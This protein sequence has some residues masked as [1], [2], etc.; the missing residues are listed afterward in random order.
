MFDR[1]KYRKEYT[2]AHKDI[3]REYDKIYRKMHKEKRKNYLES[4]KHKIKEQQRKNHKK[5]RIH[6]NEKQK[7]LRH[8]KGISKKYREE[9]NGGISSTKQYKQLMR[10]RRRSL[11]KKA[12]PLTIE[13]IQ[14]VYEDN[15]KLYGTLTCYLCLK[16]IQFGD[17]SIDHK[18]PLCRSGT[19]EYENLGVA[20]FICNCRKHNKTEEGY[21]KELISYVI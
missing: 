13:T 14:Q 6:M 20:H 7:E 19:N 9:C 10:I 2:E 8:K 21:R 4:N 5:N 3:K 1:K 17:D 15:I 12:G 18:T 11:M 16:L